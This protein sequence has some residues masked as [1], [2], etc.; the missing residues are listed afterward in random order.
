MYNINGGQWS[1][2]SPDPVVTAGVES[3]RG[4]EAIDPP[5]AD[6][7]RNEGERGQGADGVLDALGLV[8]W[9]SLSKRGRK[10]ENQFDGFLRG[11]KKKYSR[12][13]LV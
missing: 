3:G 1:M 13:D 12:C 4:V 9:G 11:K 5:Q 2:T 6:A 10:E 8:P 7:D